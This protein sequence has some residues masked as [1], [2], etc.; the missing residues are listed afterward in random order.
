MKPERPVVVLVFAILNIIFGGLGT[1]G[2]CCVGIMVVFL[3]A[4]FSSAPASANIPQLPTDVVVYFVIVIVSHLILS[5]LLLVSGIGLL[6]MRAWARRGSIA[7]GVA[8]IAISMINAPVYV[9]FVAPQMEKW[10]HAVQEEAQR[11]QQRQGGRPAPMY[12]SNQSPMANA[13]STIGGAI[14]GTA[15]AIALLVV[16]LLPSVRDAFEGRRIR[17]RV[18]WDREENEE[19]ET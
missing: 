11:Q 10:Q 9:A 13:V 7:Y 3:G 15:Y 16:M 19:W 4:I 8:T 2:M 18:D 12:Q 1:L 14:I 17:R 6:N 5:L